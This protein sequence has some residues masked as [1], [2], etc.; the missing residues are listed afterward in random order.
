VPEKDLLFQCQNV[1]AAGLHLLD[2]EDHEFLLKRLKTAVH[3]RAGANHLGAIILAEAKR[4]KKWQ[5]E[6]GAKG[7]LR[8]KIRLFRKIPLH[9]AQQETQ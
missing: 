7:K 6:V 1:W 8:Q 4:S 3:I 2:E 9:V 5:P